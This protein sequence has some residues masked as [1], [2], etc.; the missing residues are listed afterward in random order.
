[1]VCKEVT[2]IIEQRYPREY[3][4]EWDNVGLLAGRDDKE[5][6]S[7]Y[8]A[9]DA[10]DEVIRAARVQGADMLVTHHPLIFSG[11]KRITN[12]D[13][14]GRRILELLRHDI[15]YYAM[16]T[17]YDVLGMADLAGSRMELRQ[18]EILEVTGEGFIQEEYSAQVGIGR[19]GRLEKAVTLR[20]CCEDVKQ[21]FRLESVRVFGDPERL[22]ER[23]A[24]CPGSGKSVIG[25]ALKKQADVLVTGDIGHHD[26]IDA[27]AQG[28]AVIDAGHY[29]L[30]HI[31]VEDMAAYLEE[32]LEG[33]RIMAAP[34]CHPFISI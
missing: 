12:Q 19:V 14:I 22:V 32:R 5:V 29:G 8:L 28:M 31:F 6:R 11:M 23:I 10:S 26:G 4:L 17:N 33:I 1:M 16:H 15:S 2:D 27:A 21:A 18:P 25:E 3:A 20:Q 9:L 13:F 34:V 24:I 30:E 7:I